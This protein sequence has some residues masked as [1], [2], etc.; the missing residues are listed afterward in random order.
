MNSHAQ[1][2]SVASFSRRL[3][4]SIDAGLRDDIRQGILTLHDFKHA[5]RLARL[6]D[7]VLTPART[8]TRKPAAEW[9]R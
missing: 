2:I 5:V 4:A 7:G 1:K 9:P 8:G 3:C 6:V